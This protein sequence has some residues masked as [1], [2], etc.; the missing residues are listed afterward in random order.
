M[1]FVETPLK[2]LLILEPRVFKDTRGYFFESY[3]QQ[4]YANAGVNDYDWVQEN[5]SKSSKGV[6]RGMHYQTGDSAQAKLVR[7][8]LGEVYDVA[9]DLR[10]ESPTFGQ[11]FGTF[12]SGENKKQMLIPRGF[13]HGFL[14][15][16][17]EAIFSYK[18][19]NY[20]DPSSEAGISYNDEQI[21]IE[22]P[23][24]DMAPLLSEKDLILDTFK[25]ANT[26]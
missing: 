3:N 20:Y 2:D 9:V 26:F 17:K 18:C 19:D 13:A 11:H 12:L 5:E 24:L 8:I 15:T 1:K 21:A 14:V 25:D 10:T 16:S 4:T 6:L 22:W 23:Q 7:V